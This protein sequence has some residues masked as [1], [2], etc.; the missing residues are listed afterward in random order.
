[1]QKSP[2]FAKTPFSER[3]FQ[4]CREV[5][6]NCILF[7]RGIYFKLNKT[8]NSQI[9]ATHKAQNIQRMELILMFERN[10]ILFGILLFLM[11]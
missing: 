7:V 10:G 9:G 8:G 2:F 3:L 5:A 1:M 4:N 6:I 11:V